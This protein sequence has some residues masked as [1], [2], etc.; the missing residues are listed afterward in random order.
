MKPRDLVK[1]GFKSKIS[2]LHNRIIFQKVVLT[3]ILL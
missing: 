3:R 1:R 2:E